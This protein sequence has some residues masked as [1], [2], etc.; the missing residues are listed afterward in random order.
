MFENVKNV[1]RLKLTSGAGISNKAFQAL[2][3]E[4]QPENRL[5]L[6]GFS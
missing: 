1:A 6:F 3:A 5:C 2:L 4:R